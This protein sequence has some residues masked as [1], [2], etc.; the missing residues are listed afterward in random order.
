MFVKISI[1][2]HR[3]ALIFQISGNHR[4]K[5][6]TLLRYLFNSFKTL[7]LSQHL[8]ILNNRNLMKKKNKMQVTDAIEKACTDLAVECGYSL[9][10]KSD[11]QAES[12]LPVARKKQPFWHIFI[13][14]ILLKYFF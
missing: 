7:C 10:K 13:S 12:P 11:T 8:T 1:L 5:Q 3:Y 14:F 4:N 9:I 2:L 6:F